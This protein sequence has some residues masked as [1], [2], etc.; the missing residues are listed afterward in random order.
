MPTSVTQNP[1]GQVEIGFLGG[2][3][4]GYIRENESREST[5]DIE[6]IQD[7]DANDAVAV[8]S[9]PGARFTV[10]GVVRA[11]TTLPAKGGVVT[12]GGVGYIV[13]SVSARS[14]SKARRFSMTLY[15]PTNTTWSSSGSNT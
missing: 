10:D 5:A 15:K 3:F 7:E 2:T 9:N 4:T 8:V 13:E 6:Y 1:A 12:Y 14:T 11:G